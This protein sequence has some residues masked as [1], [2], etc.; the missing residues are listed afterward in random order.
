MTGNGDEGYLP[1]PDWVLVPEVYI[2]R[3]PKTSTIEQFVVVS[4][5]QLYCSRD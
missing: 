2:K 5:T 4:V 3:G 1:K